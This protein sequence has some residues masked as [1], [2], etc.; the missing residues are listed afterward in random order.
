[1]SEKAKREGQ[2]IKISAKTYQKALE[3]KQLT[4]IPIIATIENAVNY[5]IDN[6]TAILH[7]LLNDQEFFQKV[8]KLHEESE[9]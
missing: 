8:K 1:M 5:Y 4:G 3:F 9:D 2:Q 6:Y 7:R